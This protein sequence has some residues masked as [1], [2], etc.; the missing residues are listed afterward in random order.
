M[1]LW[2][3]NNKSVGNNTKCACSFWVLFGISAENNLPESTFSFPELCD[4]RNSNYFCYNGTKM[5]VK[6]VLKSDSSAMHD[7]VV[8]QI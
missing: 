8:A 4:Y 5:T 3:H 7:Q 6:V 2:L 1:R